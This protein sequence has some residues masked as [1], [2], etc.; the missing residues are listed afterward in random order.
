MCWG[1]AG[2]ELLEVAKQ[3]LIFLEAHARDKPL[4]KNCLD[5]HEP[6][7][8]IAQRAR[9]EPN[10]TGLK[11]NKTKSKSKPKQQ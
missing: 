7:D 10:T 1:N 3:C 11:Q 5:V 8:W 4:P 2:T 9:V 6:E